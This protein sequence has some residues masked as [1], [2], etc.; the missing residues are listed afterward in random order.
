MKKSKIPIIESNIEKPNLI[1]SET[2]PPGVLCRCVFPICNV[3]KL[4]AIVEKNPELQNKN[5]NSK[6]NKGC[7]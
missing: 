4:N 6:Q 2:L 7:S 3:D 1:E 5:N